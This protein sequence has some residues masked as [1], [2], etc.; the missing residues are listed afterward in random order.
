MKRLSALILCLA[1][2]FCLVACAADEEPKL[3]NVDMDTVK[4]ALCDVALTDEMTEPDAKYISRM[5]KLTDS[6]YDSC[7]VA[8]PNVG[9][10]IDEFGIFKA[11]DAAQVSELESALNDYI[12]YRDSLWMDEYLP[13]EYPKLQNA[14]VHS[15]GLYVCYF[16]LGD[17]VK[18]DAISA[19]E[20][21]FE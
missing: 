13:D 21:C 9:T 10:N 7:Y 15:E 11:R 18:A 2:V 16:I 1:M 3:K 17:D 8:I 6:D 14:S 12:S 4:T 19:F 5:M 20:G